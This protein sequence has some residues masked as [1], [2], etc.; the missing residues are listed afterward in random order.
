[1]LKHE[2]NTEALPPAALARVTPEELAA[3]VAAI[4]HRRQAEADGA[5]PLGQILSEMGLDIAEADLLAE[6]QAQRVRSKRQRAWRLTGRGVRTA[7]AL[8][9]CGLFFALAGAWLQT[10]NNRDGM[11]SQF[12]GETNAS[13]GA[14]LLLL[15]R[16]GPSPVIRT[17]AETPEGRTTYCSSYAAQ[18]AAMSRQYR[19]EPRLVVQEPP[20]MTWPVVKY[21]GEL[22]LRGW[23]SA[24]FSSAAAKQAERIAV[25]NTPA[26]PGM[27]AH[28]AQITIRLTP[29]IF[30]D[31]V[32]YQH[33]PV[34]TPEVFY[35]AHLRLD[36][37]AYEKWQP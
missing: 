1:M 32:S 2:D 8:A 36:K 29:E 3:A 10:P 20:N 7:S 11:N 9:V 33:W 13:L 37:H 17:L 28:P 22:Y 5:Q 18:Y 27:G 35:Y 30:A 26:A 6:V 4:E 19:F 34:T 16:S 23:T 14:K 21:H 15:D 24:S 31:G 25:Y 12:F